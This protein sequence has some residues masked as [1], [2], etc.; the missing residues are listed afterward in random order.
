MCIVLDI[1]RGFYYAWL[2]GKKEDDILTIELKKI[3][4]ESDST[5]V[6]CRLMDMAY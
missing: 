5:Y 1:K 3:L 2:K 6:S 4:K